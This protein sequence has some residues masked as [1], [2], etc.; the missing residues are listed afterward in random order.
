MTPL[1][2]ASVYGFE[3]VVK[4]PPKRSADV[5]ITDKEGYDPL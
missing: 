3:N 1:H 2:F 4:L 5:G